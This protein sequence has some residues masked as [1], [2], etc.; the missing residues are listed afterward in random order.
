MAMTIDEQV[1][2]SHIELGPFQSGVA[3][4]HWRLVSINWPVVIIAI[5]AASR[6]NAPDEYVL[7]FDLTNY[8]KAPP[9][10]LPWNV[11]KNCRLDTRDRPSGK[12][13]VSKAFRTDWK[14]GDALY[15]PCDRLAIDGHDGWK[16]KHPEMIWNPDRDITQYL[17]IVHELLTSRDYTGP[18][19]SQT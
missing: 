1:F 5:S 6:P 18:L 16:N 8:P 14:N 19:S 11:E 10:A 13:R 2:R 9:T 7:R 17:R 12:I 3:R 4:G 15:L